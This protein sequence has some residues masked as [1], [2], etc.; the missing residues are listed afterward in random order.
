MKFNVL[1]CALLCNSAA[2]ALVNGS[3][4]DG[5]DPGPYWMTIAP[6]Q[7]NI[8]GWSVDSGTV[9]Y[10]GPYWPASD[11][12][13]S[14]DMNG[15]SKGQ[16][17]QV[18][19]TVPGEQYQV[20]FDLSGNFFEGPD[21]KLLI[22]SANGAAAQTYSYVRG[23]YTFQDYLQDMHW[24]PQTYYFTAT[25]TETVLA[26]ASGVE[27][28]WGPV[29]DNVRVMSMTPRVCHRNNGSKGQKTLTVGRAALDAHLA[30]GDYLGPCQ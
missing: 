18:I 11:G 8:S 21:E 10:M 28:A 9:D 4:E 14:I 3:F 6:G 24:Q 29:I 7:T 30:H 17:S 26:F 16:I 5:V 25:G 22:V 12:A 2:H 20:T 15:V 27:G 13:R 1:L 23:P 19:P